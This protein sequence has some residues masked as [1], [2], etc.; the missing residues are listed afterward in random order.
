LPLP[1]GKLEAGTVELA[2]NTAAAGLATKHAAATVARLPKQTAAAMA[3][4]ARLA[5]QAKV[6]LLISSHNLPCLLRACSHT[7]AVN[8]LSSAISPLSARE[9]PRIEAWRNLYSSSRIALTL[10]FQ[11]GDVAGKSGE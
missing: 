11:V 5:A 1:L 8:V 7:L 9:G 6:E 10:T 3:A 4:V 2:P